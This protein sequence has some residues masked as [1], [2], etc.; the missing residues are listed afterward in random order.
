VFASE[1][2][3]E[4]GAGA[5]N[6]TS[7]AAVPVVV[8]AVVLPP[9]TGALAVVEGAPPKP[10]SEEAPNPNRAALPASALTAALLPLPLLLPPMLSVSQAGH[11]ATV[12][13]ET[14]SHVG[15]DH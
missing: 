3:V 7:E 12:D 2:A 1:A 15:Q 5:P 9:A 14:V 13:L 6:P 10:K 8:A 4:A 11:L